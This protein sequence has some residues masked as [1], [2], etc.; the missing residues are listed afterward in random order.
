MNVAE[1]L[2][3]VEIL[4]LVS[5]K[6]SLENNEYEICDI[7]IENMKKSIQSSK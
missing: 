6:E 7:F 5:I 1:F 2:K 4:L 3:S